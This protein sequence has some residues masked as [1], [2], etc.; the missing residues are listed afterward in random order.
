MALKEVPVILQEL[1]GV[2]GKAP[3]VTEEAQIVPVEY[4]GVQESLQGCPELV[5]GVLEEVQMLPK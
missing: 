1:R 4:T 3:Q 2:P 5:P